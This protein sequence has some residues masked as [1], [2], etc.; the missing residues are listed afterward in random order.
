MW[1]TV[2]SSAIGN[3]TH[4]GSRAQQL[5]VAGSCHIKPEERLGCQLS[6]RVRKVSF[7]ASAASLLSLVL[8]GHSFPTELRT[9]WLLA[10]ASQKICPLEVV[11]VI[12]LGRR[13]LLGKCLMCTET[14]IDA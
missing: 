9:V 2:D 13:H 6:Q 11:T 1:P 10:A 8:S 3:H 14:N 12:F 7:R 5:C 4:Y